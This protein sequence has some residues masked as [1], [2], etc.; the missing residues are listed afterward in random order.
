MGPNSH[1]RAFCTQKSTVIANAIDRADH[2][3]TMERASL[4]V[5]PPKGDSVTEG[6][7]VVVVGGGRTREGGSIV[8]GGWELIVVRID[9]DDCVPVAELGT[10]IVLLEPEVEPEGNRLPVVVTDAGG[11]V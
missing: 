6:G 3:A 10:V 9:A 11:R 5:G 4:G 2:P 1:H 7:A 8:R